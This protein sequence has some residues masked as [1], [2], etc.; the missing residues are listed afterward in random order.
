MQSSRNLEDF[1][2]QAAAGF[3]AGVYYRP[4]RGDEKRRDKQAIDT[5]ADDDS[6]QQIFLGFQHSFNEPIEAQVDKDASELYERYHKDMKELVKQNEELQK[7]CEQER[8]AHRLLK[9]NHDKLIKMVKQEHE[10]LEVYRAKAEQATHNAAMVNCRLKSDYFS[11]MEH[12]KFVHECKKKSDREALRTHISHV[13][14]IKR[15]KREAAETQS[16]L[17]KLTEKLTQE[18]QDY[19]ALW[20]RYEKTEE[21]LAETRES[22]NMIVEFYS[23]LRHIN[24]I[25]RE[26]VNTLR[27]SVKELGGKI[28]E[29]HKTRVKLFKSTLEL[30]NISL[31]EQ[32]TTLQDS[33]KKLERQLQEACCTREES[34]TSYLEVKNKSRCNSVPFCSSAK[35]LGETEGVPSTAIRE[36]SLLKELNHPNI[37]KL[38]DVIHTEN[39]LYLVFEFLHQ[40]LKKFMDSSSVTGISLPL[41]KSYLFQLLQGLSFCHSHRVLHRD[42]KP[43]NLLI[44][45]QGEIKL[46]DFG[47]ARAFGVPVRT[48][49]H[50]VVTLWYRAPEIL[51]GCKFYSTAVDIWSLGCIFAE[52][53]TRRALFPGDSEIDQLFRIFRTLG[54]PDETVWPGVTSMPDYKPSFPKWALQDL[55]KVV[56]PLDDDGRDL[57]SQMLRYDPNKRIS[58]KNALVHRFFRDVTMPMPTLS[59]S[60]AGGSGQISAHNEGIEK[61][62]AYEE[63]LD[64]VAHAIKDEEEAEVP[65]GKGNTW[66][67]VKM[68]EVVELHKLKL[69]ELKQECSIR[70]LDIKGN[71]GDLIARLQAYIDE[72]ED[73]VNEEEVLEELEEAAAAEAEVQEE[74][75]EP[76]TE[77][78]KKVVKI[79]LSETADERLQKRAER[80]NLP[81]TSDSKKAARAARFGLPATSAPLK[82]TPVSKTNVDVE[83]LKKRAER[84]GMNVSSVSKKVEEEEKLKKRKERFGIVTTAASVGPDDSEA[85]KRKRAERFGNV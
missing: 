29:D 64:D 63:L 77:E 11:L 10:A 8:Q 60:A 35:P 62:L 9:E 73:D 19:N 3:P 44:N 42:L 13:E 58:A 5:P 41:V 6:V 22:A 18:Q 84:F 52:M 72:H 51:L 83:V 54:T 46:A 78:T 15:L 48:Y 24:S 20:F 47:L 26:E 65:D 36:I 67:A 32:V 74:S 38:L 34:L 55:S 69:A 56:P 82:G 31:K 59:S 68:A 14:T 25:L 43:Q 75:A 53:I 49:T 33:V 2:L 4:D 16:K 80:F 61:S 66:F 81:P 17:D 28:D 50:E 27:E 37:V 21:T 76:E 39:K 71:K 7:E 30:E 45:A 79:A 23:E 12:V 1:A 85:K 40:D 57:L 70:G